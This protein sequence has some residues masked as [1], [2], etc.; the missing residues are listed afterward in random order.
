MLK[1]MINLA[2]DGGGDR[3]VDDS[4][5]QRW[6]AQIAETRAGRRC[7]CWTCPS[8]ELEDTSG[9]TAS[10]IHS[11]IVLSAGAPDALVLLFIDDDQLSYL[12]LAPTDPD[13]RIDEFPAVEL[14][15]FTPAAS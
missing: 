7:E 3:R 2:H 13:A 14:I 10:R 8:I 6:F 9:R 5:R 1:A 15:K 11:R 4:S 12:E